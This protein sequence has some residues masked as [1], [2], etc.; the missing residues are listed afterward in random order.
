MQPELFIALLAGLG[1]MFGWGLADFFAKKTIDEVGDVVSLVWAHVFGTL[2]LFALA[3]YHYPLAGNALVLPDTQEWLLLFFF[4]ALQA[5]VYLFV[6]AGFAKGQVAVLSPIFASF[7]GLVAFAS[8]LLLGEVVSGT[9]LL[10]LVLIFIG[11]ILSSIDLHVAI[12]GSFLAAPGVKEVLLATVLATAWTL[13][14]DMFIGGADWMLYTLAMYAFMTLV[15]YVVARV[16]GIRLHIGAHKAH[17]WK[18][19]VAIGACEIV[20]YLAISYGYSATSLTSVVAI[21]SGAFSLPVIIL[22]RMFLNERPT[23]I[24]TLGSIVVILGVILL[25]LT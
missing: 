4:G 5:A 7:S 16:K 13:L 14:W 8:V 24:Q 17:V 10:V 3:I 9:L 12:R 21:L 15:M 11:V 18:F 20:A 1:G 2:V 22:A 25:P 23:K 19:L 6:Y